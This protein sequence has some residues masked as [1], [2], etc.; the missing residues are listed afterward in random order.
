MFE[1]LLCRASCCMRGC[2]LPRHKKPT[3]DWPNHSA[4]VR[5]LLMSA[6]CVL[7]LGMAACA[8]SDSNRAEGSQMVTVTANENDG[9]VTLAVGQILRVALPGNTTTGYTWGEASVPEELERAG[10]PAFEPDSAAAGSGGIVTFEYAASA[11]G[12][13]TLELWYARPWES[14]QPQA[15]FTLDVTVE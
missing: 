3:R 8:P 9:A 14:V 13:G 7:A 10:E 5:S 12:R 2:D 4:V 15:K 11:T 1:S 6:A